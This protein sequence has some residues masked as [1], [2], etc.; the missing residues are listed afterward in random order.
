MK[1]DFIKFV[2]KVCSITYQINGIQNQGWSEIEGFIQT[3]RKELG[4]KGNPPIESQGLEWSPLL[5]K[6]L[7]RE[8]T[9]CVWIQT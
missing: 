8:G 1:C 4:G 7:L 5:S 6:L 3:L 9:R 2:S